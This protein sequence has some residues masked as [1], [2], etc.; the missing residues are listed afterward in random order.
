[1]VA[2]MKGFPLPLE[3]RLP[4]RGVRACLTATFIYQDAQRGAIQVPKWFETD[5]AS[6]KPLRTMAVA[7]LLLS[8]PVGRFLPE[9]GATIGTLGFCLL[10]LYA[11][12]VGYGNAA[13]TIHD[14]LYGTRQLSRAASDRVFYN[15]LRDSHVARWRAWL[16]YAGVRIGGHWRYY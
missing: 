9:A 15:A 12:V 11:S 6:V 10:A 1:M 2:M 7:L 5:F 13:A 3:A 4:I 16:M 14:Y 8:L